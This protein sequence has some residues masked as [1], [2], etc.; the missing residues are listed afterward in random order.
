[1]RC[2]AGG[3]SV[4]ALI[5]A[6]K[7]VA[8]IPTAQIKNTAGI[9]I[10]RIQPVSAWKIRIETITT[11]TV[12]TTLAQKNGVCW[13]GLNERR[14]RAVVTVHDRPSGDDT[15][16]RLVGHDVTVGEPGRD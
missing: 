8:T 1:M 14:W 3:P 15:F 5:V 6:R 12:A 16:N 13:S 10:C 9:R 2:S 7:V 11:T 4:S